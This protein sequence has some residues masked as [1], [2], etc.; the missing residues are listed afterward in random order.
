MI[1]KKSKKDTLNQNLFITKFWN[2]S[3]SSKLKSPNYNFQKKK[4][5]LALIYQKK[6]LLSEYFQLSMLEM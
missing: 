1:T 3:T 5:F 4:F 2:G 6:V